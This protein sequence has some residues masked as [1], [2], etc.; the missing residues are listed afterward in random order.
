LIEARIPFEL[1][2]DRL[3]DAAHVGPFKTLI[4]PNIA[5]LSDEQCSQLREFVA[6]GGSL[7]ATHETSLY[8]EWG[9]RRDNFGLAGLFGVNYGGKIEARM[10]N[11]YL[12]LEHEAT[13]HHALLK[14]L[15]DA[16][17]I[18]H[19]VSRVEV[20]PREKF[21][22]MP[23]TLIPSYP[24][25]PMEKVYPRVAETD[26]AQVYL[27]E[28]G[29]GRVGYFPW[30]IDRTFWEVL[31]VDHLK[32]LRNAVEW[33]TNEEP[34]VTVTGPGVLDVTVWRQK[35]SMTVHLVNLTNP[36]MMKGPVRELTPV[37]EQ[38]VHVHLPE[39]MKPRKVRLLA[40]DKTPKFTRDGSYLTVTV[41]SLLDHEIV[42]I[43]FA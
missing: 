21:Q 29:K 40:A 32:L 37:G 4:L 12:R 5:A 23:L 38:Q 10:Q 8:D 7:I 1:V 30:D 19:G 26:I 18:I 15:E 11:A 16:P 22:T 28:E 24:D 42:A 3:L 13:H 33:A 14:G 31:C 27:R 17:R 41:P 25:L 34:P 9:V 2:H 35:A 43:D 39:G 6:S 36:M 20:E